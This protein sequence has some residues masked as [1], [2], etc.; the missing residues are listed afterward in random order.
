[1]IIFV[2]YTIPQQTLQINT[3]QQWSFT[4]N[5]MCDILN[6]LV[7][8]NIVILFNEPLHEFADLNRTCIN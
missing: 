4:F 7:Y 3:N 6:I 5:V 8:I 2:K 1:M